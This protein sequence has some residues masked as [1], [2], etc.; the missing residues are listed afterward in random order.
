MAPGGRD[1]A[2]RGWRTGS[3]DRLNSL[4]AAGSWDPANMFGQRRPAPAPLPA[5]AAARPPA[6]ALPA[7][8]AASAGGFVAP[9]WCVVPK[10]PN[11]SR[12][13]AMRGD[14]IMETIPINRQHC[15]VFGRSPEMDLTLEHPSISRRHAAVLHHRSGA[16]YL[17]DLGSAH[18]TFLEGQRIAAHDPVAW[19]E[20]KTVSFGASS[21]SHVLLVRADAR[22]PARPPARAEARGVRMDLPAIAAAPTTMKSSAQPTHGQSAPGDRETQARVVATAAV[23]TAAVA[24]AAVATAA[25]ATAAVGGATSGSAPYRCTGPGVG[26]APTPSCQPLVQEG[27]VSVVASVGGA[28]R[29]APEPAAAR[30]ADVSREGSRDESPRP[31]DGSSECREIQAD[32]EG[33]F[34]ALCEANT[35]ENLFI[36]PLEEAS[37]GMRGRQREGERDE[38]RDDKWDE[39]RR[40]K[41]K[42]GRWNSKVLRVHFDTRAPEVRLFEPASPDPIADPEAHMGG[43]MAPPRSTE[44]PAAAA[45]KRA[46]PGLSRATVEISYQPM[47]THLQTERGLFGGLAEVIAPGGQATAGE[48]RADGGVEGGGGLEGGGPSPPSSPRAFPKERWA[49]GG[50]IGSKA[51][52]AARAARASTHLLIESFSHE[53][54]TSFESHEESL[55]LRDGAGTPLVRL[56]W[57]SPSENPIGCRGISAVQ[58]QEAASATWGSRGATRS[59]ELAAAVRALRSP[60]AAADGTAEHAAWRGVSVV[61]MQARPLFVYAAL[62]AD[63]GEGA[64]ASGGGAEGG[65]GGDGADVRVLSPWADVGAD[66]LP[67]SLTARGKSH[68][69]FHPD[70]TRPFSPIDRAPFVCIL[71]IRRSL[72]RQLSRACTIRGSPKLHRR[73]GGACPLLREQYVPPRGPQ[74]DAREHLSCRPAAR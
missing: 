28:A 35:R 67:V 68:T 51:A 46:A 47:P 64:A 4:L 15:Y 65:G 39:K 8:S 56:A 27:S 3:P 66:E 33:I 14:E 7:A 24:T 58:Y 13:V 44:T 11:T 53:F 5:P 41:S 38:K 36:P 23:A 43:Y 17:I 34:D 57:P 71:T 40:E 62:Q 29:V 25:V 30:R 48:Q 54:V 18:G 73:G 2:R 32:E 55:T 59:G 9:A 10:Q 6:A 74:R 52:A 22:P 49:R 63:H 69:H 31:A 45:A 37:I 61:N 50:G 72:G 19:A 16:I 12:L 42:H 70:V 1:N 26:N 21:R 60:P 20:G